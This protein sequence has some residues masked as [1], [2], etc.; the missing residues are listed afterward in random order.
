[1][2]LQQLTEYLPFLIPL[3]I[4]ELALAI[5]ALVHVLRHPNYRFG[6]KVMWIII[7]LFLQIIGPVVYFAFGR[8]DK[9]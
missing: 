6:N 2:K 8:G 1:M 4:A 9:A 3:I 5:T 7:V